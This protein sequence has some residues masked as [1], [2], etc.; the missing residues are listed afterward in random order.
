MYVCMYICMYI[1]AHIYIH[2]FKSILEILEYVSGF[3][4]LVFKQLWCW[5]VGIMVYSL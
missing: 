4:V 2:L 5:P 1:Y 3:K